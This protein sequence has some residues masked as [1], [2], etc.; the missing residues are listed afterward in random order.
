[1]S[2]NNTVGTFKIRRFVCQAALEKGIN[3]N[4]DRIDIEVANDVIRAIFHITT[5][6]E[7][8]FDYPDNFLTRWA[9]K[10][11][12]FKGQ[13]FPRWLKKYFPIVSNRVWSISK[14]PELNLPKEFNTAEFIHFRVLKEVGSNE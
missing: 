6:E 2:S 1:M 4:P 9:I 14:F 11:Q 8:V 13:K 12:T 3:I 7:E 10:W 5:L